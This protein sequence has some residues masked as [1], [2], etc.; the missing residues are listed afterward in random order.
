M[1]ERWRRFVCSTASGKI[2]I[3]AQQSLLK[4]ELLIILIY[5][6]TGA[7]FDKNVSRALSRLKSSPG[8]AG[9]M[10]PLQ[11]I[12]ATVNQPR[13]LLIIRGFMDKG[14]Q[15]DQARYIIRAA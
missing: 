15:R 7:L 9:L 2:N 4:Q 13:K 14:P 8:V 10:H 12:A 11:V 1:C 5:E 3:S 6:L